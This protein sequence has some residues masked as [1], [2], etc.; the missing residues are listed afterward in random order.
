MGL[1]P[2]SDVGLPS[3]ELVGGKQFTEVPFISGRRPRHNCTLCHVFSSELF[4]IFLNYHIN[5]DLVSLGFFLIAAFAVCL[6]VCLFL[7]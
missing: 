7:F 2:D 4:P 6:F 3:T 5:P 1:V